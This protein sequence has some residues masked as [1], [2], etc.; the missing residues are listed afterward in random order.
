MKFRFDFV[1]NSS[2]S[3]FLCITIPDQV[4]DEIY[5]T[6][7]HTEES[8]MEQSWRDGDIFLPLKGN[9][10]A[11]CGECGIEFV[12]MALEESDLTEH[13]LLELKQDLC[14]RLRKNYD[15]NLSPQEIGFEYGEINY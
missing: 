5:A 6:N 13:T 8:L 1:T 9:I 4:H 10:E 7:G 12:G 15:I 14:D 2:S 3:S 11:I